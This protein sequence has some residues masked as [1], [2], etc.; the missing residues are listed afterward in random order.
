MQPRFGEVSRL[1]RVRRRR[2]PERRARGFS[3]WGRWL[4]LLAVGA[5][6]AG[7]A[8]PRAGAA[9]KDVDFTR[10]IRPIL[11]EQCF[12]CH[13]PDDKK[14]KGKYRVDTK[15][16]AFTS[17]EGKPLI[18]PGKSGE[19]DF[20]RRLVTT[21]EDDQMPPAKTG[22]KLTEAQVALV[23][24]WIDAGAA[25]N[26]HWAFV[27]PQR[28]A[29]PQPRD[30]GWARNP[31]DRFVLARLEAE[32]KRPNPEAS[33]PE[34]LRRATLDLTGL[35]PTPEELD[36][37]LADGEA[38]AYE[39]VVDR[40]LKSPRYGE[41]MARSW[42]DAVRYADTHGYHI[43]SQ[44]DIWPYREWVINAFNRNQPF[45]QFTIDQLAGDLL[46]EPTVEQRVAT[47]FVRCNMST[48][49]GGVIEAEY[50]AKYAF[51]RVETLG[52]V[53]L[54]VTLICSRCHS[55]KYDPL[56]ASEYYGVYS[57]FN[58]LAEPVMDGN[59]P[60]P[61]PF[62]QLPTP[63]QSE[64]LAWLKQHLED[65]QRRVEG[66]DRDLDARQKEW[67]ERLN[68]RFAEQFSLL[69]GVSAEARVND[70]TRLRL[71]EDGSVAP[72]PGGDRTAVYDGTWKLA[73]G[74]LAGV[75]LEVFAEKAGESG[76]GAAAGDARF[77]VSEIEAELLV[78]K[79]GKC[80]ARPLKFSRAQADVEDAGHGAGLVIDG[81]ADTGWAPPAACA[82]DAHTMFLTLAEAAQVPEDAQLHVKLRQETAGFRR[83]LPR[84]R[85]TAARHPDFVRTLFP[86]RPSP[87][88]MIGPLPVGDPKA[89]LAEAHAAEK[90]PG[91]T[92]GF[93][94]VRGEVKW[95]DAA[96][97]VDGRTHVLVH[98]LHG[99]HGAR[100]L[101]RTI[102]SAT[103]RET[104]I[105]LRTEGW[106]RLW[107]NGELVAEKAADTPPE[108]GPRRVPVR[109]R[110]GA[111]EIRV[112]LVS[113]TG[114]ISFF[115]QIDPGPDQP[116]PPEVASALVATASPPGAAAGAVR[117]FFRRQHSPE[118][119]RLQDEVLAMRE[120]SARIDRSIVT[121][122]VAKELPAPRETF[123]L[124]R[125]EYDK[126]A[127]KVQPAVF[128][129]LLPFPA[130]APSNRLGL[131]RWL[132]DPRHP[133][134]ARVT[135]NRYWQHYFGTGLVKTSDDF[136]S[137]G[138]RP[139]HPELLDWLA[140]AFVAGGWD[141]KAMQRL[142]VTSA[143]YRQ[144]SKGSKEAF[145]H[146]P[147]NRLLARGPRHRLD[148]EVIRDLALATGGLLNERIGGPSVKPYEPPGL[149][150]AVSYNN[151][152][153]YVQ[154]RGDANYRRSLYTFWKRQSPPP[155]MLTFD[156]PTRETCTVRR[157]RTNTP[158]QALATL[159]DP[160]YV[161]A[162][163]AFAGRIL[164]CP[165]DTEDRLRWAFRV[166]TARLP[167]A[168]ETAALRGLWEK[169]LAGFRS[170]PARA[171]AL[172][173]VGAFRCEGS[174]RC[175]LAA[176]ATVANL[177][178]NLDETIT[179]G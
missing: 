100:Y 96:E 72:A 9:G 12:T 108:E 176:W 11:S 162:S 24:R 41:N 113:V 155:N 1:D 158:M 4:I 43:D 171:D 58:N 15:D 122:L 55:H 77:C 50:A 31:I 133:L 142:I 121:T 18:V 16:G 35:P 93:P 156:A 98:E 112:K 45:D 54:G 149:W 5:W 101:S 95:A 135:V 89:T 56:P 92:R 79:D 141:V 143:T 81:K 66:P 116:P 173:A 148:G 157:P 118:V 104:E 46:S 127:Q 60:N 68:R 169:Q 136:G 74:P 73:A 37:F 102:Q 47:G 129:A 117:D 30:A 145:A 91:A 147:E 111:N 172:L 152:Q 106:Y 14:R 120:E 88:R 159:N 27:T 138:E 63:K 140:T 85:V 32:G 28:P 83:V 22:K 115:F 151:A 52:T 51:D 103:E 168:D 26:E 82:S 154:D 17:A 178:L 126:P 48:G 84:F 34:L 42:L 62:L 87:W 99:V 44:R 65:G 125:G 80:E 20:L 23:R 39:K 29:E 110:S 67:A 174:D 114:S 170:E 119:R 49:E 2:G 105:G 6:T 70:G 167:E 97:M 160:Q 175:E 128:S 33:K 90:E 123:F 139:S 132:L 78:C 94:G 25:W 109:L 107:V 76:A 137:Q 69:Q 166:A 59:K 64:R 7:A 150:E 38:Q 165:G 19:S 71:Q 8:A 75:R 177:L 179:K 130:E 153:V 53:Y 161:E 146:D 3:G 57:F 36:A 21:D 163:R 134:T 164:Q 86:P 124:T 131:A 10:D 61:D 144:S 40:L 13:G